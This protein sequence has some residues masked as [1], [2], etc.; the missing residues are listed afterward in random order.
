MF[1]RFTPTVRIQVGS[2]SNT[3]NLDGPRLGPYATL[4]V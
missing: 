3:K 2:T 1:K 4:G